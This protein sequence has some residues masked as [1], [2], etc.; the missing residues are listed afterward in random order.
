V[1]GDKFSEPRL[2]DGRSTACDQIHFDV[3][4]IDADHLVAVFRKTCR[5]HRADITEPEHT[6]SHCVTVS[7]F[8]GMQ[9]KTR[10]SSAYR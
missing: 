6:D 2:D 9:R 5:G 1:L 3:V 7:V 8:A 4:H 10:D